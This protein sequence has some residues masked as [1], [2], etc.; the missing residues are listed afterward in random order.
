MVEH[1]TYSV[2]LE[3]DLLS[4]TLVGAFNE[5]AT[6]SVCRQIQDKV[7]TLQGNAFKF[8]FNCIDYEGSTPAAHKISNDCLLWLNKQNCFA[9]AAVY[10][11]ALY[12]EMARS[13]QPAMY[14]CQNRRE[15]YNVELAK[16]WLSGQSA[17]SK[18]EN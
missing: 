2:V 9:W 4:I 1:G 3:D 11:H 5:I 6:N 15:F 16:A 13:Q 18:N 12:A 14:E 8:L 7:G 17:T 10:H